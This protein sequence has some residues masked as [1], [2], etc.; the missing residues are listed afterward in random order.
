MIGANP[1]LSIVATTLRQVRTASVNDWSAV[2]HTRDGF[3][4]GRGWTASRSSIASAAAIHS[5]QASS[6]GCSAEKD[7]DV[8]LAYGS[9]TALSR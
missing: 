9:P 1:D 2:C 4:R 5:R 3:C 6:T 7:I 8:A